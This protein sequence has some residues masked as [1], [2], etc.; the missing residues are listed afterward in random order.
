MKVA[1]LRRELKTRG[2]AT[3]GNKTELLER[4]Q[5][6]TSSASEINEEELLAE[7]EEK[8]AAAPIT[9]PKKVS[10]KRDVPMPTAATEGKENIENAPPP[11]K[12]AAAAPITAGEEKPAATEGDDAAVT[13]TDDEKKTA[14][15][16][17]AASRAAR[18][19]LPTQE[20]V[21]EKKAARAARF[22]IPITA[23]S[24][25]AAASIK[26]G[27]APTVDMETLKKRAERFGQVS[28]KTMKQMELEEK[29]KKRQERFGV[30]AKEE[31]AAAKAAKTKAK[32]E[33]AVETKVAAN[34][35]IKP[36]VVDEK[37]KKRAE[38]FAAV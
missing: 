37:M 31:A 11:G 28:S 23:S 32:E 18:F 27:G 1:D 24:D 35:D 34:T 14:D 20:V 15:T 16:D 38:R 3:T 21:E 26:I 33:E 5:L 22:G 12:K 25:G 30:V 10:I 19:G 13:A 4:L 6:A 17:R 2:L 29:I 9:P 36:V 8:E 7:E